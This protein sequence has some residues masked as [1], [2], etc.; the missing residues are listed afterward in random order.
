VFFTATPPVAFSACGGATSCTVVTDETGRVSTFV[1]VLSA[2]VM[3]ITAEL[4][5]ASYRSPQE[6]IA[7]LVGTSSSL[8]IALAP[9]NTE[10]AQ[11]AT[12]N[13]PLTARVLSNGVPQPNRTVDYILVKGAATLSV[14]SAT[15]DSSGYAT[16]ILE[17]SNMSAD[18]QVAACV[19]SQNVPCLTFYGTSVPASVIQLQGVAGISQLVLVGQHFNQ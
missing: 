18:V 8:D 11:G 14:T 1:T 7:D 9:Q 13:F 10:I 2:A 15:T 16:S 3:T 5:P 12:V 19:G 6:A 17:I 4:A